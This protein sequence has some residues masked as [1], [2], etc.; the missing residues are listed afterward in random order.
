MRRRTRGEE[1]KKGRKKGGEEIREEQLSADQSLEKQ[2]ITA[3]DKRS[4]YRG[5]KALKTAANKTLGTFY[6]VILPGKES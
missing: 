6:T 3:C 4:P 5:D 1:V 2:E